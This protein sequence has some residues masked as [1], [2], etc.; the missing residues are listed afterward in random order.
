MKAAVVTPYHRENEVLIRRCID[1][2]ARQTTKCVHYLVADG[3][4]QD[5]INAAYPE[6]RHLRLDREHS[7]FGNTPRAMGA[8]LAIA[9]GAEAIS[10]LDADNA[11]DTNH[12]EICSRE[13]RKAPK[14]DVV[15]S[16][17]RIVLPDGTPVPTQEE[18]NHVD[19]NCYFLLP[20]AFPTIVNWILQ[21]KPMTAICDRVYL[22]HL[23]A[24]D[25]SFRRVPTVTV[26][27]YGNWKGYYAAVGQVPPADAKDDEKSNAAV[28]KWWNGLPAVEQEKIRQRIGVPG[29]DLRA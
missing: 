29:F 27:Y 16:Q 12:V 11:I 22:M 1:S 14:P 4:Y 9:V 18:R 26:T 7:D 6:I 17:R 24:Q 8:F 25:L 2:V 21:P 5:W 13:A 3:H 15:V 10:F 28:T 20:N 23:L 19:T